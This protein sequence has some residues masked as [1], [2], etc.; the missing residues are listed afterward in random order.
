[1]TLGDISL[2]NHT[3]DECLLINNQGVIK[4][5]ITQGIDE[6]DIVNSGSI[7]KLTLL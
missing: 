7:E 4:K 6:R 5:L 1:M 2:E 3:D